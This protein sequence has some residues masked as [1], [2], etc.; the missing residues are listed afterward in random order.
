VESVAVSTLWRRLVERVVRQERFQYGHGR[1][2]FRVISR[3][4]VD[5]RQ[6]FALEPE[7]PRDAAK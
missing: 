2:L 5:S 1:C 4:Q 7:R 3:E 6:G